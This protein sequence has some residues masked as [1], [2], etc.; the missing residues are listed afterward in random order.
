MRKGIPNVMF[1]IRATS[2][3]LVTNYM[4]NLN[5]WSWKQT[6]HTFNKLQKKLIKVFKTEPPH[7]SAKS[8]DK[9]EAKINSEWK[10]ISR[11]S[12]IFSARKAFVSTNN[13]FVL[14]ASRPSTSVRC[15]RNWLL[16]FGIGLHV[17]SRVDC[18]SIARKLKRLFAFRCSPSIHMC[19]G[20]FGLANAIVY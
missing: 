12:D 17:P 16:T 9:I 7:R 13:L 20:Q 8:S 18:L 1:D 5:L 3:N 4:A 11:S 14:L 19:R 6:I 10:K 2:T 15:R